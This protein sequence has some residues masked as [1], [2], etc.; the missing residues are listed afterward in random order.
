M[1]LES[2][3]KYIP[4]RKR[5]QEIP[6]FTFVHQHDLYRWRHY[7]GLSQPRNSSSS[8]GTLRFI[9][10][11]QTSATELQ[12]EREWLQSTS[13]N[14]ISLISILI[15][16]SH[17]HSVLQVVSSTEQVLYAVLVSPMHATCPVHAIV[18]EL[19]TPRASGEVY[20]SMI[21][22]ELGF[23]TFHR[24]G[25]KGSENILQTYLKLLSKAAL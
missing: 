16:S 11:S 18:F 22:V 1:W 4:L 21:G 9:S 20:R 7:T 8:Y 15:I 2:R 17:T 25:S 6:F 14:L 10:R 24:K 12:A 3:N 13:S 5:G 23:G 19:A